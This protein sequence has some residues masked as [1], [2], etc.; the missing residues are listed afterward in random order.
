MKRIFLGTTKIYGLTIIK[1][2]IQN[3][4]DAGATEINICFDTRSHTT[5][6]K[7]LIYPNMVESHGPALVV[8]NNATFTKEDFKNNAKLAGDT[9]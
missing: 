6:R 4:D 1:E 7:Y 9:K 8:H 3:A 2:L 5:E